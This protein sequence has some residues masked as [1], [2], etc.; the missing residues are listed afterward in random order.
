MAACNYRCLACG[1]GLSIGREG[2]PLLAVVAEYGHFAV[3][4]A[5]NQ[6]VGNIRGA[7][8]GWR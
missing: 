1:N 2:L 4:N 8:I 3:M 6:W 7:D 5:L